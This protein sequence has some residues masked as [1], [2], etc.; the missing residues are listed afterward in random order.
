MEGADMTD[1]STSRWWV[2]RTGGAEP[3]PV[4]VVIPT[5]ERPELLSEALR[6]ALSQS[7]ESFVVLVG[8]NSETD[9]SERVVASFGDPRIHYH[10]N[11]PGLG[12]IE[13]WLD[14]VRRAPSPLVAT[15]HDDD[16]WLPRFLASA[17]PT[18]LGDPSIAMTFT[19][20]WLIDGDGHRLVSYTES[21]SAR[22]RRDRLPAGRLDFDYSEA[23]RLVA[24]WNAPQP[25]YAA[26]C[27]RDALLSCR[28]EP[29]TLCPDI[30]FSYH[31]VKRGA[32][33][34]YE[35]S[36]LTEYRVHSGAATSRGFHESEDTVF[37]RILQENPGLPV[38]EEI[39]NY[40]ATLRW[41]RATRML[42]STGTR[43]DSQRE[44]RAAA[45]SLD[46]GR[47]M[48]AE[49]AGRSG[50]VWELLRGARHARLRYR[51]RAADVRYAS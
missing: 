37:T 30:W 41:A 36:R 24:V 20:F 34:C 10:R 27:R 1:D 45:P 33:L 8:D 35:P 31:L 7:Y 32:G 17:V 48:L 16:R 12:P 49:M 46:G 3:P 40:W 6:S 14:L 38:T 47:R 50:L 25:L 39:A 23:L 29:D 44:F 13:N 21:E 11:R 5:Y 51:P 22:T 4:T 19:D 28:F 43:H 42:H 9:H 2:E 15:L 26:V 18:M